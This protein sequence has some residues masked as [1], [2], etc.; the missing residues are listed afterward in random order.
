MPSVNESP[1]ATYRDHGCCCVTIPPLCQAA[2][3]WPAGMSGRPRYGR[4]ESR[5]ST[6][7]PSGPPAGHLGRRAPLTVVPER[8]PWG[9]ASKLRAWQAE[10]LEQYFADL[11][12]DFLAAATPGAGKTTFALRLAAELRARRIID[13]IT[14]VAPTDHLKRQWADAAARVG[15]RLDPGFRNAHG[16]TAPLPRRRRD[17]RAGGDAAR[18][19]GAHPLGPHARDPRRGAPRR[20]RAVV[21]RRDPR[22]VRTGGEAALAHGHAVP[23]RHRADPVRALR[24]RRAGRARLE[25][26]YDYGY[27]RAL[28]DGVVRP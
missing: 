7:T 11:P 22:G 16:R 28:A 24:A 26:D 25:T 12:R 18:C 10:A 20:R 5:V 3:P 19:T 23:L 9:T 1:M 6:A 21:G 14:V 4:L 17:V 13:R 15:I 8:A 27:G 2:S